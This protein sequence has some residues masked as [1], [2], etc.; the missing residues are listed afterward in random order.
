MNLYPWLKKAYKNIIYQHMI[1]QAHHAILI[2][3]KPGIGASQLIWFISRWL[4]C[5]DPEKENIC[6]KCH[7]CKLMSG[8]NHPDWHNVI[9]SNNGVFHVDDIRKINHKVFMCSQQ[10]GAKIIFLSN[11][12][13]LTESAVNAFLKTLEEPPENTWF[14]LIDYHHANNLYSTLNSRC[15]IYK[16]FSP[17]EKYSLEWLKN[18]TKKNNI[19]NL[20]ALRL[21]DGSPIFAKKFIST[22]L[23]TERINFYQDLQHAFKEKN[24]LGIL[25]KFLNNHCIQKI[26]WICSLLLDA[27]K[28][29]ISEN[30]FLT[31][32]DHV[33][34]INFFSENYTSLCLYKSIQNWLLCR[35]RL[36]NIPGI[37]YELLLTEQLLLWEQNS[38]F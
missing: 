7:G 33:K 24:L 19:I 15:L 9:S 28:I 12:K 37:N 11:I 26:F 8:K 34:L 38:N 30:T 21:H 35:Y 31:N 20:T 36:L 29:K 5:L 25:P 14:F 17:K 3:T 10:G 22:K 23:Y 18:K 16:L 4:L 32:L 6:F 27:M 13:K 1:K 2:S